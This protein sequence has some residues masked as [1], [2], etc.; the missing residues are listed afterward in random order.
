ML[1]FSLLI[2]SESSN[3]SSTLFL[4]LFISSD[5]IMKTAKPNENQNIGCFM[6]LSRIWG[7]L[8]FSS[9]GLKFSN[10][11]IDHDLPISDDPPRKNNIC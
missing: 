11:F 3:I 8:V 6:I 4:K 5:I 2:C 7:I 1:E 10:V 9:T